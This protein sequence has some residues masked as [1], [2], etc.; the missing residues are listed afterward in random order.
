[1]SKKVNKTVTQVGGNI[2]LQVMSVGMT[3]LEAMEAQKEIAKRL[4]DSFS[5]MPLC[6]A[7]AMKLGFIMMEHNITHL[8]RQ[9]KY[10][11]IRFR[12][13]WLGGWENISNFLVSS[14]RRLAGLC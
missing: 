5:K 13:I 12:D 1:M 2:P 6:Q 7:N 3:E 10:C 9:A 4:T 11:H 8:S 14:F